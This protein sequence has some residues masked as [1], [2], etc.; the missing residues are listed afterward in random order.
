[1]GL[2][3]S[4]TRRAKLPRWQVKGRAEGNYIYTYDTHN[5]LTGAGFQDRE[6]GVVTNSNRYTTGYVYDSRGN[7]TTLLRFGMT[8]ADG[9][10]QSGFIDNL[11]Y[12]Y[13]ANSN[14]LLN[15]TDSRP[16]PAGDEGYKDT[17]RR[18]LNT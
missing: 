11:T 3:F 10:L 7:I 9:C 13:G 16:S 18:E 8:D 17:V 2:G 4:T 15:V 1:M 12:Q 6:N 14:Q 5:R